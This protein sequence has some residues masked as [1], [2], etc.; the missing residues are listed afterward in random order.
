M[1]S[2]V[3]KSTN[4]WE[5]RSKEYSG[6]NGLKALCCLLTWLS[7]LFKHFKGEPSKFVMKFVNGKV[8]K[9]GY[10]LSFYYFAYNTTVVSIPATTIDSHFVFNEITKDHQAITIQ[11]HFTYRIKDP[12]KMAH[13]LDFQIDPKTKHYL[14]EDP[15]KL[16]LRIKNVVQMAT[17]N[18]VRVLGLE[19]ALVLSSSLAETVLGEVSEAPILTEMGIEVYTITFNAVKPT[20]EIAKALEAEYRESLQRKADA[21]IYARRAAAVEQERKIRENELSTQIALE[22][23]KKELISLNGD[24]I[25]QEA[26]FSARAQATNLSVYKDLDPRLVMALSFKELSGNAQKIGNLTI[27]SEILASM[28]NNN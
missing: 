1:I 6:L 2:D 20:P 18:Q 21:S 14:S 22:E 11:G 15:E 7:M 23:R 26:E 24:N 4:L 28:L 13:L 17:R 10:G 8:K 25:T 12:S 3:V 9:Q 5:G 19:E 16:E 27:T